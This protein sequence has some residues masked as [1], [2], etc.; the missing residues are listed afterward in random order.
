MS[1]AAHCWLADVVV[2]FG[3]PTEP[4]LIRTNTKIGASASTTASQGAGAS[5]LNPAPGTEA[6]L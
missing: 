4:I 1:R 3:Q 2:R 5:P 6:I